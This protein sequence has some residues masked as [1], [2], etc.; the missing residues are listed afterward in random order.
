LCEEVKKPTLTARYSPHAP[1]NGFGSN[2]AAFGAA[3]LEL[4]EKRHAADYDPMI[5]IQRSDALLAIRTAR[6]ALTR[7]D[8]ASQ[9]RRKAFLTLLLFEPRR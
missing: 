9:S 5:R 3:V 7:F 2:I 4:Q 6:A 8:K 1:K